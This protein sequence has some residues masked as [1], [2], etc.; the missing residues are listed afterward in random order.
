LTANEA[1][2]RT[3]AWHVE[4][5]APVGLLIEN[6]D[7]L[8]RAGVPLVIDHYGLYGRATPESPEGRR[9]LA[10]LALP[11][12]WVKLSDDPLCT[13]PQRAWLAAFLACAQDRCVWGSDWPHTPPHERHRGG[14]IPAPHRDLCYETLLDDMPDALGSAALADRIMWRNPARLY[15]FSAIT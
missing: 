4:V 9:L 14:G 13:R 12:V 11:H 10:L 7:R 8:A 3:M 15:G 2:A 6:A 5:I 1:V